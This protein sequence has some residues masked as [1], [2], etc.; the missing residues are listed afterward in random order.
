[1]FDPDPSSK[2]SAGGTPSSAEGESQAPSKTVDDESAARGQRGDSR[3]SVRS[4]S[5]DMGDEGS[6][7]TSSRG[8]PERKPNT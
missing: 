2:S 6:A 8:R 7:N 4:D 5:A 3:D 1:M